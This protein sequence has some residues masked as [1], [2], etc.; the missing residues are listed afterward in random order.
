[1]SQPHPISPELK[2]FFVDIQEW[3]DSGCPEDS[4]F[5]PYWGLCANAADYEHELFKE[6]NELLDKEFGDITY[7]FG[8][9]D[10][11]Q[12]EYSTETIYKNPERLAFILK[13]A[14]SQGD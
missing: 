4:Y 5:L 1:M 12:I 2:K 10:T 9:R 6:L 14:T 11:Y 13:Y 8:G 7:P 3:I